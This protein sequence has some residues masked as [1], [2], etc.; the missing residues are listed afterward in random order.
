MFY[1]YL[2]ESKIT[3][4]FIDQIISKLCPFMCASIMFIYFLFSKK[5]VLSF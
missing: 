1:Y 3:A 5:N 2:I 4:D